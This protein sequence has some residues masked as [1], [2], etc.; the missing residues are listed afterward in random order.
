MAIDKAILNIKQ[1][2]KAHYQLGASILNINDIFWWQNTFSDNKRIDAVLKAPPQGGRQLYFK[3]TADSRVFINAEIW[4][5][6][7]VER[8]FLVSELLIK[9]VNRNQVSIQPR[10]GYFSNEVISSV[11][12]A[13]RSSIPLMPTDDEIVAKGRGPSPSTFHE[14]LSF[15]TALMINGMLESRWKLNYLRIPLNKGFPLYVSS[16]DIQGNCV[17][18]FRHKGTVVFQNNGK[19]YLASFALPGERTE[20]ESLYENVPTIGKK[21]GFIAV[22]ARGYHMNEFVDIVLYAL[23]NYRGSLYD[24]V[25]GPSDIFERM[26]QCIQLLNRCAVIGGWRHNESRCS[27][28]LWVD[29]Y[30]PI[31][32][33]LKNEG[34]TGKSWLMNGPVEDSKLPIFWDSVCLFTDILMKRRD[35]KTL[36]AVKKCLFNII[37]DDLLSFTWTSRFPV[38]FIKINCQLDGKKH[39]AQIKIDETNTPKCSWIDYVYNV[40]KM[41]VTNSFLS[42]TRIQLE[43]TLI[44]HDEFGDTVFS[45]TYNGARRLMYAYVNDETTKK[46]VPVVDDF[47]RKFATV[48]LADSCVIV[49]VARRYQSAR[50]MEFIVFTGNNNRLLYPLLRAELHTSG[51]LTERAKNWISGMFIFAENLWERFRVIYHYLSVISFILSESDRLYIYNL[52]NGMEIVENATGVRRDYRGR[53]YYN[54]PTGDTAVARKYP[55]AHLFISLH[56]LAQSLPGG[57]EVRTSLVIY[58]NNEIV[59][60]YF[61]DE[62]RDDEWMLT[63]V[64]V[65]SRNPP[66]VIV[67]FNRGIAS[68]T[69][70]ST[71]FSTY[72]PK[73]I[74]ENK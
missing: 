55:Q 35:K 54:S 49:S 73:I 47:H 71:D 26:T 1:L 38:L 53:M 42:N 63:K 24:V 52:R 25:M 39:T 74:Y 68:H 11:L 45:G 3:L 44:D 16:L 14:L 46:R 72:Q 57:S 43:D 51:G 40:G 12:K 19:T 7:I 13:I 65:D 20:I 31:I 69:L 33:D 15:N 29:D 21:P 50:P 9:S 2:I 34:A 17:T 8:M 28:F 27:T 36:D 61:K 56:K 64:Y 59:P 6:T 18:R 22:H 32:I 60:R 70:R 66:T 30:D 23:P 48:H 41:E 67:E 4:P 58:L 37:N 5:S 62:K 10:P